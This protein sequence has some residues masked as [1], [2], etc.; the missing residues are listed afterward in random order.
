MPPADVACWSK[1]YSGLNASVWVHKR[2]LKEMKDISS[3][4]LAKIRAT[5]EEMYC[6]ME[7]PGDISKERFNRSEGRHGPKDTLVQAFKAYQGRVYGVEGSI[8]GK[9]AF[10]ASVAVVKKDNKADPDDLARA[11]DRV[12]ETVDTIPGAKV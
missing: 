10:F 1:L 3:K 7:E 2:C 11:V 8:D 4:D 9:R 6:T 12:L 5:M